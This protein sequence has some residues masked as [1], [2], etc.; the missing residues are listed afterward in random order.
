[1]EWGKDNMVIF[2]KK[3][4]KFLNIEIALLLLF[5]E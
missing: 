1:M 4:I 2:N 5:S 3:L